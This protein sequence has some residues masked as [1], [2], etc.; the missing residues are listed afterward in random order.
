MNTQTKRHT[1]KE[2][3]KQTV[4]KDIQKGRKEGSEVRKS[5]FQIERPQ[6]TRKNTLKKILPLRFSFSEHIFDVEAKI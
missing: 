4:K 1:K 5:T 6:Y 2:T 3:N